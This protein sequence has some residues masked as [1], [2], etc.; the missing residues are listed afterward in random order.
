MS[1]YIP[2]KIIVMW[3]FFHAMNWVNL[4]VKGAFGP[5]FIKRAGVFYRQDLMK[6]RS[7]K[8]CLGYV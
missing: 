3:L 1:N 4:F 6:S 7:R 5:L 8:I 2:H